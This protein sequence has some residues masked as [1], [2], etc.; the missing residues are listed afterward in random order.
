MPAGYIQPPT[1][2]Y[3]FRPGCGGNSI[4]SHIERLADFAA[5]S[6]GVIVEVGSG[7]GDGST[8]AFE[9]GL[10]VNPAKY[11]R[12]IS[13][14]L[15][16]VG[17]GWEPQENWK[18]IQ[19]DSRECPTVEGV[20]LSLLGYIPGIIY[21]DTEHSYDCLRRELEIW[22]DL[23]DEKTLYLFHDV[24]GFSCLMDAINETIAP[25]GRFHDTHDFLLIDPDCS[26]LGAL[27]P[28]KGWHVV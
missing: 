18:F 2:R 6:N 17:G 23:G 10:R 12:H 22:P 21:I 3:P 7:C 15:H 9:L 1:D 8:H 5:M 11:T 26:G 24:Q 4:W 27:V 13:V 19:G 28:K 14:N 20:R 16:P 25:G